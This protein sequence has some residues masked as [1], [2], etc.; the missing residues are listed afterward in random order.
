M[1]GRAVISAAS[2][3]SPPFPPPLPFSPP[4]CFFVGLRVSLQCSSK[5]R[6]SESGR[7]IAAEAATDQRTLLLS[8]LPL[9]PFSFFF[10]RRPSA[11]AA[12]ER[13]SWSCSRFLVFKCAGA[14]G[15]KKARTSAP[16][17]TPPPL[18]FFL[19]FSFRSLGRARHR[20]LLS[21]VIHRINGRG[22]GDQAHSPWFF[23][24]PFPPDFNGPAARV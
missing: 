4:F 19:L 16:G 8:L 15:K 17:S 24:F 20:R 13:K 23:F 10:F 14:M 11:T 22:D 7:L 3:S 2:P 12:T 18:P 5:K 9:P 1:S 21:L 6:S